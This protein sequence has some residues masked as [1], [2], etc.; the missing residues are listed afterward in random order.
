[1]TSH[2]LTGIAG[3][4]ATAAVALAACGSAP[5]SGPHSWAAGHPVPRDMQFTDAQGIC[6]ITV[7]YPQQAPGEIDYSGA[8]YIQRDLTEGAAPSGKVVD[9]S[10]DWTIVQ[11]SADTLVLV[12]PSGNFRYRSGANCGNNQAPPT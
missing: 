4:A 3:L 10:G 8:Q 12:T 1:M 6:A 11:P 7:R 9:R 5:S 2:R